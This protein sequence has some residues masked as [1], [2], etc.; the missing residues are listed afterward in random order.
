MNFFADHLQNM[1]AF[2]KEYKFS[3]W[4]AWIG[5]QLFIILTDPQDIEVITRSNIGFVEN[6]D[7]R[8]L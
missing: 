2:T 5:P 4:R 1:M 8:I 3:A 7:I 6:Y